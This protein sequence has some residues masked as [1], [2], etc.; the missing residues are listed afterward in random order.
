MLSSILVLATSNAGDR[1]E[2]GSIVL[3]TGISSE[4]SSGDIQIF[5]GDA[6][7][8]NPEP[9]TSK[10]GRGGSIY[11]SVGIGD[12]GDGGDIKLLSGSTTAM[13][14]FAK[15]IAA[16]GGNIELASGAAHAASSGEISIATA[17]AGR[18][19][20]SG[21]IK[22]KTGEATSGMAGYIGEFT[23]YRKHGS[24]VIVSSALISQPIRPH[25]WKFYRRRRWGD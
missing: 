11:I 8:G 19:G 15:P 4:G 13:S 5:S 6:H 9:W 25:Q 3:K 10:T 20:T 23:S 24:S 12:E 14:S 21:H 1:G 7:I 18:S 17:D 22:L 2:S 16:T